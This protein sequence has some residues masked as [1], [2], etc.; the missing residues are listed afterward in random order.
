MV[1][2]IKP[3][4]SFVV[5][6][7]KQP[8]HARRAIEQAVELGQLSYADVAAAVAAATPL[9]DHSDESRHVVFSPMRI[10][11]S[12]GPRQLH[13]QLA[14]IYRDSNF[15]VMPVCAPVLD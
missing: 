3:K 1:K 15:G 10:E 7:P 4:R 6:A 8:Q 11:H 13:P 5:I 9:F 14:R 2:P 12:D